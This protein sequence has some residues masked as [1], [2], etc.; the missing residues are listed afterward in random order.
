MVRCRCDVLYS[1]RVLTD[2]GRV[3]VH[4]DGDAGGGVVADRPHRVDGAAVTGE[5]ECCRDGHGLVHEPRV[6][7]GS[8]ARS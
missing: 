8:A 1:G 5:L 3:A 7:V 2:A 4:V 6:E